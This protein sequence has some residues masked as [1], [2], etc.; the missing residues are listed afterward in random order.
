MKRFRLGPL[1]EEETAGYIG[2]RLNHM[3]LGSA[4]VPESLFSEIFR[5]TGGVPRMITALC[6][7]AIEGCEEVHAEAVDQELLERVAW[8]FGI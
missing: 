2:L 4:M 1:T 8:E 7:A 3:R 5:R 6:G